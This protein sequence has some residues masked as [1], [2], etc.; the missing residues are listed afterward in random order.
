MEY[1]PLVT[2]K[3]LA[4]KNS[5]K[6][7]ILRIRGKEYEMRKDT[8]LTLCDLVSFAINV[9]HP[10]EWITGYEEIQ[11]EKTMELWPDKGPE[12]DDDPIVGAQ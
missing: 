7:L 4:V 12:I 6:L 10:T 8:I 3:D 5:G 9:K 11:K 2:P 1:I